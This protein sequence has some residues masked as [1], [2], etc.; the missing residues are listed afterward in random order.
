MFGV[1]VAYWGLLSYV[2]FIF[3]MV[4]KP[5]LALPLAAGLVG[6]EFYFLWVMSSVIKIYCTLCLIQFCTVMILFALTAFWTWRNGD[7]FLPGRLWSTPVIALMVFSA[8]V[9]P[10]RNR[11]EAEPLGTEGLVTYAGKLDSHVKVELF[12]DY[13]CGHCRHM[14]PEIDKLIAN[15]PDILLIFRDVILPSHKL[16]P[17]AASYANAIAFTKGPGEYAKIR[18]EMYNRQAKLY[19]YLKNHLDKVEFTDELKKKLRAKVKADMARAKSLGIYQTPSMVIYRDNKIVQ[20]ISGYRK[21]EKFSR[22]LK[23]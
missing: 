10:T 13:Q 14:E 5:S 2:V 17:V 22:F 4:Y 1:S 23:P 15:H 8:L 21:Y 18:T 7:Y 16:S 11:I 6:A 20:K 9:I 12:S 3:L 19:D